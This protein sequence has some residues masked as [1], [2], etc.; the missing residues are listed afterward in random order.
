MHQEIYYVQFTVPST[1]DY[2]HMTFKTT[3]S[4]ANNWSGTLGVAIYSNTIGNPGS[5]NTL[6]TSGTTGISNG[7]M[8]NSY[9][10]IE[11][12]TAAT[13]CLVFRPLVALGVVPTV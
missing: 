3:P 13:C 11:F 12:N 5:P 10:D 2:T 1:G 6:I 4:S 9:Q 8:D 7:N